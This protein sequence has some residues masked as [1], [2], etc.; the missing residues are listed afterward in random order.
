MGRLVKKEDNIFDK[1][2]QKTGESIIHPSALYTTKKDLVL[3]K[4]GSLKDEKIDKVITAII[5]ILQEPPSSPTPA[6][7][8]LERGKPPKK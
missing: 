2:H 5:E 7:K 8:A 1:E 3:R 4:V 6:S